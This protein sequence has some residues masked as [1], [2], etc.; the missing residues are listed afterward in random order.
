MKSNSSKRGTISSFFLSVAEKK[1]KTDNQTSDTASTS[2][3][4][5]VAPSGT[6]NLL[7]IDSGAL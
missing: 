5:E 6:S 2:A 3:E 4:K 7:I 1:R